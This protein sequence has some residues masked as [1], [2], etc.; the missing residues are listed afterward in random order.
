[1]TEEMGTPAPM[2]CVRLAGK[3]RLDRLVFPAAIGGNHGETVTAVYV[4][5]THE[6]LLADDLDPGTPLARSYLVHELV[7]AQQF[8]N[9]AHEHASCPGVLEVDAYGTQALYLR[10]RGLRE[11]AFLLQVMGMLQGACGYS[12]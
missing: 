3:E 7:H 10:T 4:P 12:D 9:R 5:A 2:A 8:A 1:M 6:I 11:E